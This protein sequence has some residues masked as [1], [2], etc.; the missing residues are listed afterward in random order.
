MPVWQNINLKQKAESSQ[1]TRMHAYTHTR[2]HAR[3]HT[4]YVMC[5][6]YNVRTTDHISVKVSLSLSM[7]LRSY[8]TPVYKYLRI[9]CACCALPRVD[10]ALLVGSSPCRA[11]AV[12]AEA[13]FEI[14]QRAEAKDLP[15]YLDDEER[16]DVVFSPMPVHRSVDLT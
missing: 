2:T 15:Y 10:V 13:I 3:I 4:Y 12:A 7:D 16:H 6:I 1:Y 5:V 11:H 14:I 9:L 8:I